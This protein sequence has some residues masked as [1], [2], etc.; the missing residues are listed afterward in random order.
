MPRL[1]C[2]I[3]SSFY[4]FAFL[5]LYFYIC[6]NITTYVYEFVFRHLWLMTKNLHM[7]HSH[8]ILD[9]QTAVRKQPFTEA[10]NTR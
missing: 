9:G 3:C 5:Y 10:R 8:Q 7:Q 2:F 6:G 4:I 1:A